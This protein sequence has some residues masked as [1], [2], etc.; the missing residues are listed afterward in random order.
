MYSISLDSTRRKMLAA[1]AAGGAM[2]FASTG[3][4]EVAVSS[5]GSTAVRPVHVHVPDADLADLRRRIKATRWPERELVDDTSQG[6]RLK[7]LQALAHYWEAEDRK[8][9][10]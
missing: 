9:V 2:L 8:S 5:G 3:F 1:T 4:A 6:V 10:V 7:T